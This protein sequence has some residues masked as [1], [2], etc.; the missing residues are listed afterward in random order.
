MKKLLL[1]LIVSGTISAQSAVIFEQ[2]KDTQGSLVPTT[3][4]TTVKMY[5]AEDFMVSTNSKINKITLE[6]AQLQGN[7]SS[8]L[9]NTDIIIL[10]APSLTGTP[11]NGNI[12]YQAMASMNNVTVTG[13]GITKNFEINLASANVIVESGKKYWIVFTANSNLASS[14]TFTDWY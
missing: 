8:I 2:V 12:I 4:T 3:S 14:S 9:A 6:G 1:A 13:T 5:S 7:L 10:E 11:F